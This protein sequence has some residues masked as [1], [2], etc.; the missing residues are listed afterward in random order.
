MDLSRSSGVLLHPTS[1]P[2]PRGIGTIGDTART[3]VDRLADAN[4]SWWQMLPLHPTGY[5]GSP[6]AAPSAFAGNPLLL[7]LSAFADRG[8][9]EDSELEALEARCADIPDDRY[10]IG[11][12]DEARRQLLNR[13]YERWV[14]QGRPDRDDFENFRQ[15]H[16]Y[17]LSDYALYEALGERHD[18]APWREWPEPLVAREPEALD[19]ARDELETSTE[20]H[21]FLQ[22]QFFR[23]WSDLRAYAAKRGV[24]L[25]GDAP[26]FVAMD[27]ADVWAHRSLFRLDRQGRPEGVAGVPPDYFSET[28]QKWGNPLYDW[29]ALAEDDYEWWMQRLECVLATVDRVRIDHFRGFEA[30]WEVPPEAPTAETGQWRDGPG[31][32]FFEAVRDHFER[33]PFIAEDLGTITDAVH[34]LRDRHGL[35][36]M[37]VMQFAFQ[38]D[39]DHPFLPHTYPERCIAYTGTHDNDTTLGWYRSADESTRHQVRAYL[40]CDDDEVIEAMIEALFESDAALTILPAQ[41]VLRLGSDARTNTPGTETDNWNWRMSCEQLDHDHWNRLGEVTQQTERLESPDSE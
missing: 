29:E 34:D 37:K 24:R 39:P 1:L 5:G 13:A 27:S 31:D 8:W 33:L 26:I 4:Q 22:W 30:Y 25:I 36:G 10:A 20:R 28:G 16:R 6:Y 12:V 17:W 38:D 21:A 2:G 32:D 15:S 9:L 41:D 18:D 11:D 3:F 35:P 40:S 7:D 19:E 23:Q 14:E